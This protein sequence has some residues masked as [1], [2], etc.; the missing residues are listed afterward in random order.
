MSVSA[1]YLDSQLE[2]LEKFG[3][4]RT[5][6][7]D[8]LGIESDVLDDPR[9]RL[10]LNDLARL[11]QTASR[12]LQ[13]PALG[14]EIGADFRVATFAKSGRMYA[15]CRN[16]REVVAMNSRYQRIAI[17]AGRTSM[18]EEKGRTFLHFEPEGLDMDGGHHII[19]L[20]FGGYGAAFTWLSWGAGIGN[21]AAFLPHP[22]PAD[23]S[24]YTEAL[25]CP[26]TF[27][28]DECRIEFFSHAVDKPLPTA[29]AGKLAIIRDKLERLL[30]NSDATSSALE[31]AVHAAI[32]ACLREGQVNMACV[33][34]RLDRTE[35]RLRT[36]LKSANLSF[37]PLMDDVRK[38]MYHHLRGRGRSL[39]QISQELGYNDQA[40]F[41]RAF[42][43]WYGK[44]PG[45]S[46]LATNA[47]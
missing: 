44:S 14:L 4:D 15:F 7:M 43:R 10:P 3:F 41:T 16:I 32:R 25:G 29:D 45:K 33:A 39:A 13:R 42:K 21:K 36:D 35:R 40:A 9:F 28:A 38:E 1:L 17:D 5:R 27:G 37:R 19:D 31:K 11:Y 34:S 47:S 46:V 2:T 6:A 22:A 18:V 8:V 20:I 26:V 23:I 30:T 12:R 24:A